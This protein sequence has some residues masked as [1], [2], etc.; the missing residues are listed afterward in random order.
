MNVPA[1]GTLDHPGAGGNRSDSASPEWL[2][3]LCRAV[4]VEVLG[5]R[6]IRC[7]VPR[8]CKIGEGT[9]LGYGWIAVVA[10]VPARVIRIQT[11][12]EK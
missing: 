3:W 4:S 2:A 5:F 8:P 9:E 1:L 12:S 10:G 6:L 7:V 11:R